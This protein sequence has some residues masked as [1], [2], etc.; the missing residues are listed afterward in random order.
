MKNKKILL[1]VIPI[2]TLLLVIAV[3]AL[4]YF[5]TD[6]FKS[7]DVLFAKYFIQNEDLLSIIQNEN[8]NEQ[9]NLRANNTYISNGDLNISINDGKKYT[10]D[11]C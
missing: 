11:K 7:N 9:T 4:L 10:R 3:L 5:A 6:M 2:L 8:L 1:T